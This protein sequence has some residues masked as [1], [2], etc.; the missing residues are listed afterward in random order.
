MIG[1]PRKPRKHKLPPGVFVLPEE[2]HR[3]LFTDQSSNRYLEL[4]ELFYKMVV[5]ES[6][7]IDESLYSHN[8]FRAVMNT[9]VPKLEWGYAVGF[10]KTY[11]V[12]TDAKIKKFNELFLGIQAVVEAAYQNGLKR[13]QDLIGQLASGQLT[14]EQLN[15]KAV[16]GDD[17]D[18][19]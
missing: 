1:E 12:A 6:T 9:E 7:P 13:G 16:E 5:A 19:E 3:P 8:A 2:A 17:D 10:N 4:S 14:I 15:K 11:R 18:D